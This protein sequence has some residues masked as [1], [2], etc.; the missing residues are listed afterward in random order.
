[1]RCQFQT[2]DPISLVECSTRV[3]RKI[4]SRLGCRRMRT[5]P[6]GFRFPSL[7]P[8]TAAVAPTTNLVNTLPRLHILP[9]PNIP[10]VSLLPFARLRG[11]DLYCFLSSLLLPQ[12]TY[13]VAAGD[14][15]LH[16]VLRPH[17]PED[18]NLAQPTS[19]VCAADTREPEAAF[20][21]GVLDAIDC[22]RH[23]RNRWTGSMDLERE[24]A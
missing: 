21:A 8:A 2:F 3:T 14:D 15:H 17:L 4:S 9:I 11:N 23:H 12:P 22:N 1:M 18:I 24:T 6:P 7:S 20:R 19:F 13:S 16:H 5:R 10:L